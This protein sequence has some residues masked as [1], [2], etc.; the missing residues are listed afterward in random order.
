MNSV[1]NCSDV[2]YFTRMPGFK[3]YMWWPTAINRWVLPRP[4]PP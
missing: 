2:T 3:R 1:R 4:T